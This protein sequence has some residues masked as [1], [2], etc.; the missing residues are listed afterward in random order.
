MTLPNAG[1]NGYDMFRF[2]RN[3]RLVAPQPWR[4]GR[5]RAKTNFPDHFTL[6]NRFHPEYTS[7]KT[8]DTLPTW[9]S[10]MY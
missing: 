6:D 9:L 7:S 8:K 4:S 2:T 3:R 10:T 5:V 1:V